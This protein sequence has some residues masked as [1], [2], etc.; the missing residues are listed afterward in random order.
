MRLPNPDRAVVDD[1]KV[2]DYLL[3]REH[4]VGQ[5][6]AAVFASAGYRRESWQTLKADL[7]A[8][9]LLDGARLKATTQ[10]G[11]LFELPAILEGPVQRALPVT[12]VWL[13]PRGGEF[14]RLVTVYPGGRRWR[15]Q[16]STR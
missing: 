8:V 11:R 13:V 10:Y 2:R 6:K 1:A 7:I 3:S 9:A 5:F 16:S 14:P 12:T 4:P 15:T